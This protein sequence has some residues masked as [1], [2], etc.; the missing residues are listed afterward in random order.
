[1]VKTLGEIADEMLEKMNEEE[2]KTAAKAGL[3]I[4][5]DITRR[6]LEALNQNKREG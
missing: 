3:M 5:L 4:S 6:A 2:I 1:M